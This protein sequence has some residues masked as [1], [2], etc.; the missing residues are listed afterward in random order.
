MMKQWAIILAMAGVLTVGS[1]AWGASDAVLEAKVEALQRQL[2]AL[3]VQQ[4]EQGQELRNQELVRQLLSELSSDAHRVAAD[5]GVTAGYDRNFF[6]KSNDDQFRLDIGTRFQFRHSYAFTDDGNNNLTKEGLAASG[7]DGVDASASSFEVERARLEFSGH[8]MKD[9]QYYIQLDMDDDD[10]GS[11]G[12]LDY[13]VSYS[14]M[15][16]LGVTVGR[17]KAAFG[18]QE[19]T[20]SGRLMFADR[21][22][23]NEVF[24]L[25][26][27]TGVEAFGVL[28][29]DDVTNVHYRA[30]VYN[31]FRTTGSTPNAHNDNSPAFAARAVIPQMGAT[32][33]D[34]ENES[35]LAYHENPVSQFGTS[36]AYTNNRSEDHFNGGE[37]DNFDVL[38][39]GGDG[40]TNVMEVGGEVTQV[41]VDWA[42]KQQGTSVILEGFYQHADLDGGE[43]M[44]AHDFGSARDAAGVKG[45]EFDNFGWTAQTGVFI[46]PQEFELICRVGGIC[47]EN[48]ND[49]YEYAA[50]WNWYPAKSQDVKVTMDVTYIDDLPVVSSAPDLD[51]VQNNSLL[52]VRSQ[53]QFQF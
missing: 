44:F 7:G 28:A 24:N 6:I 1:A 2:D 18:K 12:L 32:P 20:S 5:T 21:S 40:L 33:A 4:E 17:Q 42:F 16:E 50:G 23:V 10:G 38:V 30:G 25:G 14:F 37:S 27:G 46:V 47:V 51:G 48:S 41:G 11:A 13:I 39:A 29:V 36:F 19:N 8:I 45:Y 52:L 15:P 26:R 35:D 3:K 43:A 31:E 34:F 9:I 49:S 22:L 53:V